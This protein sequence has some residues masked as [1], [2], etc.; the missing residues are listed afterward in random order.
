MLFVVIKPNFD[1]SLE[2][3]L[4]KTRTIITMSVIPFAEMI[5]AGARNSLLK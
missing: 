5:D 4:E 2:I 1:D 3:S